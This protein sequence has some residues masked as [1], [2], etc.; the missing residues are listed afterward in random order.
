MRLTVTCG[1][2][3]TVTCGGIV[4]VSCGGFFTVTSVFQPLHA[5]VLRLWEVGVH[6]GVPLLLF[7]TITFKAVS[8]AKKIRAFFRLGRM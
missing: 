4:T 7:D 8:V 3:L 2:V 1:G 6:G 5:I